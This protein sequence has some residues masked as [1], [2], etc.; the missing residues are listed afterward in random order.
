M[1]TTN[2]TQSNTFTVSTLYIQLDTN[3]GENGERNIQLFKRSMIKMPKMFKQPILTSEYPFFT[4][5]VRYPKTIES[6]DWKTKY[7]FFFNREIFRKKMIKIT[8]KNKNDSK[9]GFKINNSPSLDE[10]YEW[11]QITEKH[12]IMVT[13]RAL[14]PIPEAFGKILKQSFED[15]LKNKMN[16]RVIWDVNVQSATNIFGF[17]Y[18]FGIIRKEHEEYFINIGGKR[19]EVNDVIWENDIVNHP[20]YNEFLLSYREPYKDV[21]SSSTTVEESYSTFSKKLTNELT[22]INPTEIRNRIITKTDVNSTNHIVANYNTNIDRKNTARRIADKFKEL[23]SSTELSNP[24]DIIISIKEYIDNHNKIYN[25]ESIS[26][27]MDADDERIFDRLLKMAI[28]VRASSIVLDFIKKNIPMN[29]SD[30]KLDGTDVSP[31]TQRI[32]KYI[33]DYF[34]TEAN[35]NNRLFTYANN[36]LEPIRKSSNKDLYKLLQLFKFGDEVMKHDYGATDEDIEEYRIA[37]DQIYEKYISLQIDTPVL[38]NHRNYDDINAKVDINK[39]LYTGVDEVKSESGKNTETTQ[40]KTNAQEIYV[41][42]DLI[43]ADA[44]EKTG[45]SSCKLFDKELE[46]DF[47]YL[48]DPR[49][50]DNTLLSKFRNFQFATNSTPDNKPNMELTNQ[51]PNSN[52]DNKPPNNIEKNTGGEHK[53]IRQFSRRGDKP[54]KNKTIRHS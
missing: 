53:K 26:V 54:T 40:L 8:E 6:A 28:E 37:L 23:S 33:R 9:E 51:I 42:F 46:Q 41:R 50:N 31:I 35:L 32:N 15:I 30:K 25:S 14:F 20:V 18:K 1:T 5:D 10:L 52:I 12:N 21:E 36:V 43:D 47:M 19:Y 17:M 4:K 39:Y 49:N 27:F 45:K 34:G 13:L 7:E 16:S 38:S 11:T 48:A 29:L 22:K 3:T 44:F 2:N 24:A